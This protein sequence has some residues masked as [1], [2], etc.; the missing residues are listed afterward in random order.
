[1][2][3]TGY[4][5]LNLTY[6]YLES[7]S[8]HIFSSCCHSYSFLFSIRTVN[9]FQKI[10]Y[11]R[12]Q[13]TF[14]FFEF[15]HILCPYFQIYMK[16]YFKDLADTAVGKALFNIAFPSIL[17]GLLQTGF[18]MTSTFWMGKIGPDANATMTVVGM[19]MFVLIAL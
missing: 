2:E 6:V 18:L 19:I 12:K 3:Y 1:M 9:I 17:A 10:L 15:F 8:E 5:F 4:F 16:D 14:A 7:C 11:K 13:K